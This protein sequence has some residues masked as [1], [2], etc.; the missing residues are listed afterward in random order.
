MFN[1]WLT[2]GPLTIHGYGFMI[3]V[4]VIVGL[5]VAE[6]K[7]RARGMSDSALDNMVWTGLICGLIGAKLL[8]LLVNLKEFLADPVRM[9]GSSGWVVYGGLICGVAGAWFYARRKHL[10]FMDY[11]NLAAPQIALAQAFGRLGCFCAGCC[12]GKVTHSHFGVVF[13]AG[14]MAPAGVPLIPTQ[15]ISALGNFTI[16]LFLH[17]LEKNEAYRDRTAVLYIM[18]YSAG[19]FLIEFLRGDA[20]RG[21]VG[22]LSTS[23]FIAVLV[24]AMGILMYMYIRKRKVGNAE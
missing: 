24:F 19:R 12:Y 6:R 1:D 14:S 20:E 7:A 11:F 10:A 17:Q 2:I 15:L 16:F 5:T 13:P 8:Y 4:G 3:A 23:Q 9:I 18:L 22:I 21:A